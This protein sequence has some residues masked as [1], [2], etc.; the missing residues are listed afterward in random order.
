LVELAKFQVVRVTPSPGS[1]DISN[2][3]LIQHFAAESTHPR[4]KQVHIKRLLDQIIS[5]NE[6]RNNPQRQNLILLEQDLYAD[7]LNWCFG[8]YQHYLG[9]DFVTISTARIQDEAHLFHIFAHELGHM[10]GAAFRG[11]SNTREELGFHCL[12]DLCV[13]QQQLSVKESASYAHRRLKSKAPTYCH[14]C[15][16]D[17]R[18]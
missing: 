2:Y 8:G 13:M 1:I 12:N 18:I 11:R 10:Y 9:K 14:Q 7:G 17:L 6:V 3:K 5:L 16:D 15:Q 4:R